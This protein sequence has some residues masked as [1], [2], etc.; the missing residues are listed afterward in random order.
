VASYSNNKEKTT[1]IKKTGLEIKNNNYKVDVS[2]LLPNSGDLDVTLSDNDELLVIRQF[3]TS[4]ITPAITADEAWNAYTLPNDTTSG[5]TMYSLV[6]GEIVFSQT[7]SDY[8]WTIF[9]SGRAADVAL[10]VLADS[11]TI[12]IIRKVFI[13]DTLVTWASGSKITTSNLNINSKQLLNHTQE[14]YT[15]FK[16]F[17]TMNPSIGR[18]NGIAPLNS[19]GTIDSAYVDGSTINLQSTNGV[20]GQGTASSPLTLNLDGDSLTQS[21]SGVKVQTQDSLTSS[22]A[23]QPLSANQ[24]K[25]LNES[26]QTLGTG[27]VYKGAF[28][29]LGTTESVVGTLAAGL[30]VAHTGSGGTAS[31]WSGT[32]TVAN[33]NLVR[34]SGSVWQVAASANSVLAD[35][36][37]E[38]ADGQKIAATP[39]ANVGNNSDGTEREAATC[40]YV[41]DAI[42]N[43][44]LDE[45]KDCYVDDTSPAS[46]DMIYYDGNSWEPIQLENSFGSG[47]KVITTG[48]SIEALG[49]VNSGAS[50]NQVLQWNGSAWV[51][52]TIDSTATDTI[53][54]GNGNGTTDDRATIQ[55]G[56]DSSG[57]GYNA[58]TASGTGQVSFLNLTGRRFAVDGEL[59][60]PFKKQIRI[61]NGTFELNVNDAVDKTLL[62]PATSQSSLS[63]TLSEDTLADRCDLTVADSSSFSA[64]D[65]IRIVSTTGI[66]LQTGSDGGVQNLVS[67]MHITRVV[68]IE[69]NSSADKIII[70]DPLPHKFFTNS[71]IKREGGGTNGADQL[72]NVVFENMSFIDKNS[73]VIYLNEVDSPVGGTTPFTVVA[74][75]DNV[76]VTLPSDHGLAVNAGVLIQ[77]ADLGGGGSGFI[78]D[79]TQ[80]INRWMIA[81][82]I[83]GSS[84]LFTF[85][86]GMGSNTNTGKSGSYGSDKAYVVLSRH[87]GVHLKNATNVLFKKCIFKGFNGDFAVMLEQCKDVT[88]EDCIFTECRG[89]NYT[90]D[91]QSN[92]ALRIKGSVGVT[93]KNCKFTNCTRGIVTEFGTETVDSA[94]RKVPS[95]TL[96]VLD[97][98]F[99]CSAPIESPYE[100]QGDDSCLGFLLGRNEI[101]N[102]RLLPFSPNP[103]RLGFRY[104]HV[105]YEDGS[106]VK[107]GINL[108]AEE[109]II[110]GCNIEAKK[111]DDFTFDADAYWG[112]G[113]GYT[114]FTAVVGEPS[115]NSG[116]MF[117]FYNG[118]Y[119]K[120]YP[121]NWRNYRAGKRIGVDVRETAV[122]SLECRENNI[123]SFHGNVLWAWYAT[124]PLG[125]GFIIQPSCKIADNTMNG[126]LYGAYL[127]NPYDKSSSANYAASNVRVDR[128]SINVT[129]SANRIIG[130]FNGATG[131]G[132]TTATYEKDWSANSFKGIW[133][134][135][136]HSAN[137]VGGKYRLFSIDDNILISPN[138]GSSN[139]K[140]QG[141]LIGD[142]SGRLKNNTFHTGSMRGNTI[143][144]WQVGGYSYIAYNAGVPAKAVFRKFTCKNNTLY[145]CVT[146]FNSAFNSGFNADSTNFA[147]GNDNA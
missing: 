74:G 8:T 15:Y 90:V 96:K 51:P 131:K 28:D 10:P 116:R 1:F 7:A 21:S 134:K 101:I 81:D 100:Q 88:F 65:I 112:K 120:S 95:S 121:N 69:N 2:S 9:Q 143:Q 55:S 136:K 11:D 106:Y 125:E 64:G 19:D 77:D 99:I 117:G 39:A 144:S 138:R 147:T 42:I 26:I 126:A 22:S 97:S 30:T 70:E 103:N 76:T 105:G 12:Y 36:S 33:G 14:L 130:L 4:S 34:Y 46:N 20:S 40:E 25:L 108:G 82:V 59:E 17:H 13:E 54:G 71:V 66:D 58:T 49:N 84:H 63:T 6:S 86:D 104:Y 87:N 94:A 137:N 37:V 3:D 110:K 115:E 92:A 113:D 80:D 23:T 118:V 98:E 41:E 72:E 127:Y 47:E 24:G 56:L 68:R 145:D 132:G 45:L 57:F 135:A 32:P 18:P 52:Q 60:L 31:G 67:S 93:V 107:N 141:I 53:L 75:N 109:L 78:V 62:K 35:G 73:K 128:N 79:E 139:I 114:F 85:T 43:T 122:T 89:P 83:D 50:N 5:S 123:W 16:N 124:Q 91:G 38:L 27:I 102:C 142:S 29:M 146:A 61:G 133:L 48:S 44:E 119:V 129:Y 140:G 111:E